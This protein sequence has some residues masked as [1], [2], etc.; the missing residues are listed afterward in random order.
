MSDN[1]KSPLPE[2]QNAKEPGAQRPASQ[3]SNPSIRSKRSQHSER[4]RH[5]DESTPLLSRDIDHQGYGDTDR[6]AERPSPAASSL[7]SLQ[8]GVFGGKGKRLTRWST[9]IAVT[10]LLII[11]IVILGLGFAAPALVEEY[12]K[13]AI[14]FEPTNL[15]IESFTS[16][17]LRA[18][19][20]GDFT[21]DASRVHK[22]SVRD[23][24][25]AGTWIAR[26]VESK[27]SKVEVVLPEYGNVLVGTADLPPIV[28]DIRN[29][30]TNHLDFITDLNA[31]DVDGM[32]R[33]ATDWLHG[34]LNRLSVKGTADVSLKSGIFSLG[35]QSLS[36]SMV[37]MGKDVP[38][39][40]KYNISKLNF[41][42]IQI[43]DAGRG[44]E[45][46]VSVTLINDYFP[47]TFTVPPLAF[48]ILVQ[49]CS[50]DEPYIML[51]NATTADIQVLPKEDILVDVSGIVQQLP[52]TLIQACQDS[53]KSPMDL[54]LGSYMS[55]EET[56]I[57]VRGSE[58]P[59]PNEPDWIPELM[60]GIIV[61]LPVPGHT[62]DNL[63]RNFSLAN[64]HFGLPSPFADPDSPE[65]YPRVSAVVKALVGL[66]E[67]MNFPISV[68]RVRADADVFYKKRKLGELDLS[69]WQKAN[70]SLVEAHG[71]VSQ[72]LAVESIVEDAPLAIT[73]D[74]VFS[75]LV[76]SLVFGGKNLVLGVKARVD[77]ETETALGKFVVRDIPAEGKVFVKPISGGNITSFSPQVGSLEILQTTT[78][79]I[80]LQAKVNI[81]NPTDYSA[82]IPYVQIQMLNNG[83]V[84]GHATAKNISVIPG[85]NHD[86][87]VT[88]L[89][90]PETEKGK[91]VGRE[92][93]SQYV[94]GYN[95]SITLRT[96]NATIPSQ[97][98]LGAALS[99]LPIELPTP[100]LK[101]PKNPN[102]PDDDPADDD[103]PHFI[104]D[105]TFHL[106]TSTATLTL[107]S[108]L[109]HTALYVTS[110]NATAYY[111]HTLPVGQVLYDLPFKVP[112]GASTSPRL[113]V[114]WTLDGLGYEAVKKAL[115]G[116]LKLDAVAYVGIRVGSWEEEIWFRGRGIGA[117]IRI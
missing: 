86:I 94:S 3:H 82:T 93:L 104:D 44:M 84:L 38:A 106:I 101:P 77:V 35:T 110:V 40:P 28:V 73:D 4:S 12:A 108:P 48:D 14:V 21:L 18:R 11:I 79:S 47:V 90:E 85:P 111:N 81:T 42:E 102:H 87:S 55:G 9:L 74:D 15:S 70:S 59:S 66:P 7:R 56:T 97:P 30:H 116:D 65:A 114:A 43:P 46:D 26:A 19:V 96:T 92:L 72:G 80:L 29:G 75:D 33:I 8:N 20:Q 78:S 13:E 2:E 100:K 49:G 25:R 39:F 98:Q 63:I 61:P 115:G 58:Q 1:P 89:W 16:S 64:V 34:K 51:A 23:L 17:G 107:L 88:A 36:E 103:S 31:G 95:T 53:Q 91:A 6:D 10:I 60:R 113:P 99:S 57:Y 45:A 24:G 62:F 5:S 50:P 76:R 71:D 37:F 41:H 105:A 112:P 109:P 52:D 67:E 54:L 32:R 68:S 69:K 22:K 83:S 27:S 117:S